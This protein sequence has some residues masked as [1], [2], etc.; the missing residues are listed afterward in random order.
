[1]PEEV[2]VEAAAPEE[3]KDG[4]KVASMKDGEY[5]LHV[6]IETAKNLS[7]EGEDT[8]DPLIRVSMMSKNKD[9][10]SK[11]DVTKSA[12]ITWDEHMFIESG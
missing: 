9:T 11:K 12:Q 4:E 3:P 10:T 2:K 1:M 7:L 6:L 8:C 5:Q